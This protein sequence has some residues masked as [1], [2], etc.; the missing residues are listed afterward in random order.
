MEA[1]KVAKRPH[2]E[3]IGQTRKVGHA[4]GQVAQSPE[5]V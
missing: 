3:L 4:M 5:H 2:E 1:E